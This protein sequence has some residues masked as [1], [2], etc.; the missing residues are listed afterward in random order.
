M[1]TGIERGSETAA[2]R[3]A[4]H[5]SGRRALFD[6]YGHNLILEIN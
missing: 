4:S 6:P 2:N 1:L 5:Y 3:P